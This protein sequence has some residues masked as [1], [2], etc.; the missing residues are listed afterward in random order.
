MNLCPIGSQPPLPVSMHGSSL[1]GVATSA[2][3]H[4]PSTASRFIPAKQ[5][6]RLSRELFDPHLNYS[7]FRDIPVRAASALCSWRVR[8]SAPSRSTSSPLWGILEGRG[9]DRAAQRPRPCPWGMLKA[10]CFRDAAIRA[11]PH[12]QLVMKVLHFSPANIGT[13]SSRFSP[14]NACTSHTPGTPSVRHGA[15]LHPAPTSRTQ[16]RRTR[17]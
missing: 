9:A 5:A 2:G 3:M 15:G 11:F 14:E 12:P 7:R 6:E 8:N 1:I 13:I 4:V 17:L 10:R 16:D